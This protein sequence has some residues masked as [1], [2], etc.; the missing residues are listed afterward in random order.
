VCYTEWGKEIYL[1]CYCRNLWRT[2][3]SLVN[4]ETGLKESDPTD[5]IN[6]YGMS[7]LMSERILKDTA[8]ATPEFK[9]AAL[10]YFNVAGSDPDGRIGQST[11]NATLLIKV[12]AEAATGKRD[13]MY[14]FGEDYPTPDGTGIRDYIHV[15][16]LAQA[17]IEA[18]NY[19]ENH[20]SD[21]FNVG[22]SRGFSV[23]EV[24]DMMKKVSGVDF[25][26]E[27]KER[28]A[29][30]PAILISDNM[31]IKNATNWKPEYDDLEVICQTT[32]NWEKKLK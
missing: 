13:K 1:F 3:P 30:D 8:F 18:L 11:K 23:K 31:K 9:Y 16:D 6:P 22:Y 25:T 27:I 21:V 5:P 2:D 10:R 12:A 24:I 17:H 32:L 7:K 14:I 28:R 29:G 20:E 19:L 26:V 15:V 4:L